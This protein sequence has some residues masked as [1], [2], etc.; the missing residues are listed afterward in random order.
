[1]GADDPA[2]SRA[3]GDLHHATAAPFW[4]PAPPT[5]AGSPPTPTPTAD[6]DA[7]QE[8][9]HSSRALTAGIAET[10]QAALAS[11][12]ETE[13]ATLVASPPGCRKPRSAAG[14]WAACLGPGGIVW[15]A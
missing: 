11:L 12:A 1:M 4:S 15:R 3:A 6:A 9:R 5:A 8:I 13:Q 7:E 2:G 14:N 10:E